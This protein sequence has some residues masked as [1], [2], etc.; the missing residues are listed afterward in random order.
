MNDDCKS[1]V[2]Y[3]KLTG[4]EMVEEVKQLFIEYAESLNVDLSFQDFEKEL[5]TL[6][7]KYSPPEGTIILALVNNKV[8]GCVALRKI[9]ENVCEM[10]R[11][12]VREDYRKIGVGKRLIVLVLE[13]ARELGY[14]YIRLDTLS[15][16]KK[17]QELY[18]RLGFYDIEPYIYNPIEGARFMELNLKE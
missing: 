4:K 13:E 5:G 15:T 6:P 11:L 14:H 18:A 7:G 9:T 1:V 3:K 8:A 10:K 2:E 12:Y 16:M 17:A